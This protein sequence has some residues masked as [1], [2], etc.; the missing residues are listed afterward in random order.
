MILFIKI[1]T[2]FTIFLQQIISN[3][4]LIGFNLNPQL[5]LLFLPIYNNQ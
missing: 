2:T 1:S 4:F 3:K 5:K